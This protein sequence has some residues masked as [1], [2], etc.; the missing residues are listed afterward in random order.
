MGTYDY[1]SLTVT[2]LQRH[3]FD[4]AR[5]EECF[6]RE[7]VVG[8]WRQDTVSFRPSRLVARATPIQ[9]DHEGPWSKDVERRG[10]P[11]RPGSEVPRPPLSASQPQEGR[12]AAALQAAE[13]LAKIA[14]T[15]AAREHAQAGRKELQELMRAVAMQLDAA[16]P[17]SATQQQGQRTRAIESLSGS[18]QRTEALLAKGLAALQQVAEGLGD[19]SGLLRERLP[20]RASSRPPPAV[21]VGQRVC[22]RSDVV[23]PAFGWGAATCGMTGTVRSI[24]EA[25]D[26]C[27]VDFPGLLR[28][29]RSKLDEVD[30]LEV[31]PDQ[32]EN[33]IKGAM[34][35]EK[36]ENREGKEEDDMAIRIAA[37]V[38]QLGPDSSQQVQLAAAHALCNLAADDQHKTAIAAAG[39]ILALVKLLEPRSSAAGGEAASASAGQE[40]SD[41]SDLD[42]DS[43]D[44][45]GGLLQEIASAALGNLA[46]GHAQIQIAITADGAIP[47]LVQVLQAKDGYVT[48]EASAAS[49]LGVLASGQL[50]QKNQIADAGAIPALVG[51]LGHPNWRFSHSAAG[52]ALGSLAYNHPQNQ[53][54]IAA[55]GAIPTLV[56]MLYCKD[57]M[58]EAAAGALSSLADRHAQNQT[59]IADA[60]AIPSLVDLLGYGAWD[61]SQEVKRAAAGALESLAAGHAQNQAA[62]AA[63]KKNQVEEE[64]RDRLDSEEGGQGENGGEGQAS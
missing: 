31:V 34:T 27:L 21:T 58:Q 62:I 26:T 48:L 2:F 24:C 29:W 64:A 42:D 19:V 30:V 9:S 50:A 40:A 55:A 46:C 25:D 14:V 36:K 13:S 52:N 49:T 35:E 53:A 16:S 20:E 57:F 56:D 63:A 47:A 18:Y 45:E 38:N 54:A 10:G 61:A 23:E 5:A 11:A 51:M 15:L 60:G 17:A 44:D 41:S 3:V 4:H 1:A 33:D 12:V 28:P 39:A 59:A 8:M 43:D 22:V 6:G 37:L 32:P 7:S